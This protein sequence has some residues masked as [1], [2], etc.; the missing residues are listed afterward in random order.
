MTT[1][2]AEVFDQSGGDDNTNGD[3]TLTASPSKAPTV[4]DPTDVAAT[5]EPTASP[6]E[7]PT[8]AAVSANISAWIML[9]ALALVLIF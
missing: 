1:I 2:L 4:A 9:S 7:T 5:A 3:S 6:S 8:A